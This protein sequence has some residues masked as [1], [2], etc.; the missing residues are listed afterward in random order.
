MKSSIIAIAAHLPDQPCPARARRRQVD[1]AALAQVQPYLDD[2]TLIVAHVDF[3]QVDPRP[4][5]AGIKK[6]FANFGGRR[7][8]PRSPPPWI[9]AWSQSSSGSP[10]SPRP[11]AATATPSY[12]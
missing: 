12:R 5:V 3:T 7:R 11:V 9:T 2:T 10:I 6:S 8:R 1:P 4:T